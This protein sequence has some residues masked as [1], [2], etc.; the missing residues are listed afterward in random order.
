MGVTADIGRSL[1]RGPVRVIREHLARGP[2]EARALAFLMLGC[3]LVW[4]GQWPRLMREAE[5]NRLAEPPGAPFDQLAGTSLF[6]WA[7]M[8]PLL[9]YFLA[10]VTHLVSRATGGRGTPATA[11]IALFWCW[12]AASPLGLLTGIVAGFTG[13]SALTNLAGVLWLAVFAAF[14]ALSQREAA[15]GPAGH[16]A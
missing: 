9:F 8:V 1:R 14:W 6:G 7:M 3:L 2:N 4:I 12:L 5:A 16:G 15:R 10:W 11:R 13:A